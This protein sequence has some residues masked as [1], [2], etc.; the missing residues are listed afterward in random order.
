MRMAALISMGVLFGSPTH[1]SVS[2]VSVA[3]ME[4]CVG[5]L[6]LLLNSKPGVI[7]PNDKVINSV[8]H[9]ELM[10]ILVERTAEH[11]ADI[12]NRVVRQYRD[13]NEKHQMLLA[14]P[15]NPRTLASVD[16]LNG[17]AKKC[18]A[19]FDTVGIK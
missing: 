9:E 5:L 16:Y 13:L 17:E 10:K 19:V 3:S 12:S 2:E 4:R 18:R 14:D 8:Q 11:S 7:K 1:A 15:N 6:R